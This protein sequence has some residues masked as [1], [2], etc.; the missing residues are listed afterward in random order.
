MRNTEKFWDKLALRYA[1]RPIKNIQAYN[2]TMEHT[3]RHLSEDDQ[4]LE[5]GCGTGTTALILAGSVNQIT[6]TDISS[7]MIEIG[8]NK[9]KKQQV[10]NVNF[11]RS[12]LIDTTLEKG[13]FDVV[14]AFNFI[15]LLED[16]S[17][18]VR[19]ISELLKPEGLFISK[20]VCMGEQN[21]LWRILIYIMQRL[22]IAPYVNYLSILE[23]E[24]FITND[25]FQIVETGVYPP[26]PPSRFIV[27]RKV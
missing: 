4:V 23:L 2:E 5:V 7:K 26:S 12:T 22:G 11:I 1:K 17:E 27:A 18:A 6:A 13:S 15:H 8:R 24:E 20:T 16:T 25:N 14:L 21:K 19:R 9:A 10:E 3:K